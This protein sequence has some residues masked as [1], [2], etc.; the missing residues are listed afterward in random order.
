[1]PLIS[2]VTVPVASGTFTTTVPLEPIHTAS[3]TMDMLAYFGSGRLSF[4]MLFSP[5]S[6]YTALSPSN[7]WAY[8]VLAVIFEL[9]AL[10]NLMAYLPLVVILLSLMS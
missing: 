3:A 9:T 6:I 1:M 2:M 8:K 7:S 4:T 10:G 5:D